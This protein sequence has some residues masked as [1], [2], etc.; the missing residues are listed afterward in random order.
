M[1]SFDWSHKLHVYVVILHGSVGLC[2]FTCIYGLGCD[3]KGTLYMFP[4][5]THVVSTPSVMK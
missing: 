3:G 4:D 2:M 1:V 5:M